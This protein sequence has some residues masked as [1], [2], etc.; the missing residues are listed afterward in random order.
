MAGGYSGKFQ[1]FENRTI[2]NET[3]SKCFKFGPFC[4]KR[5]ML[6][7]FRDDKA[8]ID[9]LTVPEIKQAVNFWEGQDNFCPISIAKLDSPCVDTRQYLNS[10][11]K[12]DC[13]KYKTTLERQNC[14]TSAQAYCDAN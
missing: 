1:F 2:G 9:S 8:V 10:A 5:T 6:D 7:I 11:N 4:G 13:Q 12:L 3:K 14:R